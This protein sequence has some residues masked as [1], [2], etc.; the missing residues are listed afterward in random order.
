MI[1]L[2]LLF[3]WLDVASHA[4]T[5][6]IVNWNV[7]LDR[8]GPG[9]LLAEIRKNDPEIL[10]IVGELAQRDAG[11]VLLVGFD[12]DYAGQ[13]LAAFQAAL[14]TAGMAY[15]HALALV[16][17]EGMP[18]G[19]DLD[20]N[21][22]LNG[23]G[24]NWGFGR[25]PGHDSMVLLSHYPLEVSRRWSEFLWAELPDARM[26]LR[27]GAPFPNAEIAAQLRLSSHGHWDVAVQTPDG[28]VHL[29]I[30]YPTPPAFDGP[31]RHNRLRN[32]D[33]IAF[34]QHYLNGVPLADDSG[35]STPPT[36]APFII[37]GDLN[38]DSTEGDGVKTAIRGLLAH[39]RVHNP[40][41]HDQPTAFWAGL[42]PMRVDYILPS[43]DLRIVD[44]GVGGE[45]EGAMTAHRLV[46]LDVALD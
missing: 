42:A 13:S 8:D 34:W 29:L 6:R 26:P 32:N 35:D 15:P 10:A 20:G 28:A 19:L 11:I 2:A 27:G 41:A 7:A 3:C 21:G 45:V 12:N 40:A 16:G 5:L 24:D 22:R 1:R 46:W 44:G 43:H 31:E 30:S 39:P 18:S 37:I 23:W 14:A 17:N 33:E 4:E 25:Y 9:L 38:A 36:A